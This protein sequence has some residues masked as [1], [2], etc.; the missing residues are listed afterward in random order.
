MGEPE[1][2]IEI[3]GHV[4]DGD[5]LDWD[6]LSGDSPTE[7]ERGVLAG[8]KVVAN[9]ARAHRQTGARTGSQTR[10]DRSGTTIGKYR[11][12]SL[13]GRG[14]M[15]EV[16]KAWDE[17]LHRHVAIKVV[18]DRLAAD[19][20][21]RRRFVRETRAACSVTHPY[22]ATVF[23]VVEEGSTLFLVMEYIE[24][25]RLD[26]VFRNQRPRPS[27]V[28]R[29]GLEVAEALDAI[30]RA[31]F[32]HRDLKPANV[33]IRPGGHVKVLDFGVARAIEEAVPEGESTLSTHTGIAGTVPYMSPE[34]LRGERVDAR[35][36]LF[37]LGIVLHEAITGVH[38]FRRDSAM[39]TA[40]AILHEQ[41]GRG[42]SQEALLRAGALR[43]VVEQLLRKDAAARQRTSAEVVAQLQPVV[44]GHSASA[45]PARARRA[46]AIVALAAVLALAALAWKQGANGVD[47]RPV[48]AVLPFQDPS[49][50]PESELTG[51]VVARLLAADLGEGRRVV[52]LGVDRIEEALAAVDPVSASRSVQLRAVAETTPATWIV[53]GELHRDGDAWEVATE[54]YRAGAG[55]PIGSFR[56]S[57]A[58]VGAIVDMA[59]VRLASILF[60]RTPATRSGA[61]RPARS[62]RGW[63]EASVLEE[64][65]RLA[66]RELR[67]LDAIELLEQALRHA[68]EH[69]SAQTLHAE[70]LHE[71]GFE[72]RAVSA[73]DRALRAASRPGS[74]WDRSWTARI[75]ALRAQLGG[76]TDEEVAIWETAHRDQPD[77]PEVMLKLA[78]ARL[79]ASRSG[80]A[81][82]VVDKARSFD[83]KDAR[84]HLLRAQIL[85]ALGRH[86]DAGLAVEQAVKVLP[87]AR[88]TT[89]AAKVAET[90][91][92]VEQ[93]RGRL[94]TAAVHYLKA[95][96]LWREAGLEVRSARAAANIAGIELLQGRIEA[97]RERLG[98]ALGT[99]RRAGD[100]RT[101]IAANGNLAAALYR[102]GDLADA[103][104]RLREAVTEAR[105]LDNGSLLLPPLVNL[106][107]LLNHTGRGSEG[108]ALA[109]EGVT[110]AARLGDR[111]AELQ[112][113]TLVADTMYQ[114]GRLR[115]AI[116]QYEDAVRVH[117]VA[118]SPPA[119][120][121][122]TL[123]Y[124]VE[125]LDAIG[126]L[127]RALERN[128]RSV[129]LAVVSKDPVV[130]AY[131]LLRRA[132]LRAQLGWWREATADLDRAERL[133]G[134]SVAD[135]LP[136][137]S[138]ARGALAVFAGRAA[139]AESLLRSTVETGGRNEV[140]GLEFPARIALARAS[141]LGNRPA[142]AIKQC[143]HVV[144]SPRALP[145]EHA[146]ARSLLALS[147]AETGER[148]EARR[149]GSRAIEEGVRL[150]MP[151]A[152][153]QGAAALVRLAPGEEEAAREHGRR[154]LHQL[155]AL[156]PEER[157]LA[158]RE[159]AD[160]RLLIRVLEGGRAT[161]RLGGGTT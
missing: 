6:A 25:Q 17:R 84:V 102:L 99:A 10:V 161:A 78:G 146:L 128:G 129:E 61:P 86:D 143:R 114:Q 148:D 139:D 63:E 70:A 109:E 18:T 121:A 79:R 106:A 57:A 20:L 155:L 142:A 56:V 107:S 87:R 160:L 72:R 133:A 60:P 117:E 145:T 45:V 104:G 4:S 95:E 71:A 44:H 15:G 35:S 96:R 147:L 50:D 101:S 126:A 1:R 80:E 3:A 30:H 76:K 46:W 67:F 152:V 74:S 113:R 138:L 59:R 89:A 73:A 40:S 34:Q 144:D 118:G 16:Y 27:D 8:L 77:D 108:G 100:F 153:L 37:S 150:G 28:A 149:T 85:S 90:S 26:L 75:R 38:P 122:W 135:L 43:P 97:A 111:S 13:L 81:L 21:A 98:R 5:V 36:D 91:A 137:V 94:A 120:R 136:R 134:A 39:A 19:P 93:E 140:H 62:Y 22:V 159:R 156:V 110:I 125:A 83:P 7:H 29:I 124:L 48:L 65:A 130:H 115:D 154:A 64:R 32:V 54:V 2:W 47:P 82:P 66:M 132:E 158:V 53:L 119:D 14:G 103:E 123:D 131:V 31:G 41:P 52:P 12:L 151:L 141:L 55:D 58:S 105:R 42:A 49:G 24:G 69:V 33:M 112:A 51:S 157:R 88:Q 9:V 11:V 68:P 127:E 116:E 23:D 92:R